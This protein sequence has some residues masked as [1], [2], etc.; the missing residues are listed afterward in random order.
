MIAY[1]G[2]WPTE[3]HP[4]YENDFNIQSWM[5]SVAAR[6]LTNHMP[7]MRGYLDD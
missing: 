3:L 6:T 5:Q 4:Q 1:P 7:T 2:N